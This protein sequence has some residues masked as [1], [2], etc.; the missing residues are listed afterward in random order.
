LTYLV[1]EIWGE[2][3]DCDWNDQ[4][5]QCRGDPFESAVRTS[6]NDPGKTVSASSR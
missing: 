6:T 1:G 3:Q 2:A 4:R 5:S